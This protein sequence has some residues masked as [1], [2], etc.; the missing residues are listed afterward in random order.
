MVF[1]GRPVKSNGADAVPRPG[2]LLGFVPSASRT[3]QGP[4]PSTPQAHVAAKHEG[5]R[6]RTSFARRDRP[7]RKAAPGRGRLALRRTAISN[8]LNPGVSGR[9]RYLARE[10]GGRRGIDSIS[11]PNPP[12][13]IA[14]TARRALRRVVGQEHIVRPPLSNAVEKG[15]VHHAYLFVG[16]RRGRG[17]RSMAKILA[18]SPQ[19]CER[20]PTADG[21]A[22]SASPA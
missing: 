1:T 22:A 18:L 8:R 2:R 3:I 13:S 16:S 5:E 12:L 20:G 9:A 17:R 14:A 11:W 6:R 4:S 10:S 15:R 21:P 7:E 19:L